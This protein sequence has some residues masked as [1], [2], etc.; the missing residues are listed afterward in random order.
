MSYANTQAYIERK[1]QIMAA[2]TL[3]WPN[4]EFLIK[5]LCRFINIDISRILEIFFSI[6]KPEMGSSLS[7]HSYS[8][9]RKDKI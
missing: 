1:E 7:V 3:P 9:V 5:S 2:R 6:C 8:I 4:P